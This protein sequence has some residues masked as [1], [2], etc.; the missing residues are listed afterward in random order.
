MTGRKSNLPN[1]STNVQDLSDLNFR[2]EIAKGLF[3]QP[4]YKPLDLDFLLVKQLFSTSLDVADPIMS[5]TVSDIIYIY[6]ELV[7][8]KTRVAITGHPND[9][10]SM[11]INDLGNK[12]INSRFPTETL[13]ARINLKVGCRFLGQYSQIVK[14]ND[15]HAPVTSPM[16]PPQRFDVAYHGKV[17]ICQNEFCQKSNKAGVYQ[18]LNCNRSIPPSEL[19]SDLIFKRFRY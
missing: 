8:K 3:Y 9:P 19:A 4:S 15:C 17:W 11:L 18:C 2:E 6:N 7:E 14:C 13:R 1:K 5:A 12:P 16:I 10:I